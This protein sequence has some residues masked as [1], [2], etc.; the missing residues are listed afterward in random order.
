MVDHI[1]KGEYKEV[2]EDFLGVVEDIL[3]PLV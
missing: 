3:L 1:R 2:A